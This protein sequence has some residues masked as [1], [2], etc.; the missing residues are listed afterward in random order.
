MAQPL[1]S[2]LANC[3]LSKI[4]IWTKWDDALETPTA[5]STA[6]ASQ[7]WHETWKGWYQF[8]R[9]IHIF[10]PFAFSQDIS[11]INYFISIYQITSSAFLSEQEFLYNLSANHNRYKMSQNEIEGAENI[12]LVPNNFSWLC[13]KKMVA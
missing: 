9:S 4:D 11:S 8:W 7:T 6:T 13:E 10:Y 1:I 12:L 5:G 2:V 3:C